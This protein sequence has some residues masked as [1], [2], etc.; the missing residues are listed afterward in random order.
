MLSVRYWP[1]VRVV[2]AE[3][4]ARAKPVPVTE[5][6]EMLASEFPV[7]LKAIWSV[8]L[9]P[10]FTLPKLNAVGLG[11]KVTT[12]ACA[13]ALQET[14]RVGSVALLVNL[15]APLAEPEDPSL[16]DAVRLV[17]LPAAMVNGALA[18]ETVRPEP[19]TLMPETV[20]EAPPEF[21]S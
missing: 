17:V 21:A 16:R 7:F 12:A 2:P 13:V 10:T 19:E 5:M 9:V 8:S 11:C 1:G 20:I 18:P 3:E 6:P 15:M 4:P 14:E